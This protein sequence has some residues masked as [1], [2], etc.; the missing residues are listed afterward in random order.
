VRHCAFDFVSPPHRPSNIGLSLSAARFMHRNRDDW[1]DRRQDGDQAALSEKLQSD[2]PVSLT[3]PDC[4]GSAREPSE[5]SPNSQA[6]DAGH[7]LD[8][9]HVDSSQ[10]EPLQKAL[11]IALR[12]LIER[13]NLCRRMAET[14]RAGGQIYSAER[15]ENSWREAKDR[16]NVLRRF[17]GQGQGS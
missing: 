2:H 14:S 16:A 15:W 6:C 5:N 8:A 10:I 9:A 17:L 12:T 1:A 3:C 11:V 7:R 4:G 13:A